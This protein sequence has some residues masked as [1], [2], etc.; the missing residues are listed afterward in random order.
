MTALPLLA[1]L[2]ATAIVV[3]IRYGA[4]GFDA[5]DVVRALGGRGEPTTVAIVQ[6][7]RAPRVIEAALVG[8]ALALA[9][10]CYQ[11][12][13][14]NALADPYIL[15]IAGGASVGSVLAIVTGVAVAGVWTLPLAGF[16]GAIVALLIVL[17]VAVVGNGVVDPRTML[18]AGVIV[19]AFT[20]AV[21]LLALA[22]SD[23]AEFRGAM[24]WL[25]GSLAGATWERV[26]L[27]ALIT[28]VAVVA[29]VPQARAL[30]L[31][32]IGELTAQVLGTRVERTKWIVLGAASL[33]TASAVAVS[34]TIGFVGL[35][36]P[37]AL[38]L[39]W[40]SDHRL[41][42]PTSMLAG[43]SFLV[44]ADLLARSAIAPRE[45][46]LGVITALIGVPVFVVLLRRRRDR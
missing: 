41:L 3:A 40:G 5:W 33:L 4:V 13:L 11:A 6:G 7:L 1:L 39:V 8:A 19:G 18:L 31:L 9:G 16:V 24:L 23:D 27:L 10:T 21:V 26:L 22:L 28:V 30:N 36:I 43:A 25:M 38:R 32:A 37:N 14:R 29:L 20:N 46:P 42:L 44:L 34:G 17:R 35:V 12:L 45:L 15:G 2:L